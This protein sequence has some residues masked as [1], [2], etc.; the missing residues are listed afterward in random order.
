[1]GEFWE[2]IKSVVNHWQ[3]LGTGGVITFAINWLERYYKPLP[4]RIFAIVF[5]G[6][7][8]FYAC[9]LS[10]SDQHRSL[11]DTMKEKTE[12]S[13]QLSE[14]KQIPPQTRGFLQFDRIEIPRQYSELVSG[15]QFALNLYAVNRGTERVMNARTYSRVFVEDVDEQTDHRVRMLVDKELMPIREQ[16]VAGKIKGAEVGVGRE[17]WNTVATDPLTEREVDGIKKGT[18]RIYSVFWLVWTDFQGRKDFSYNCRWLQA[19]TLPAP[20]SKE[21]IVWH[22]CKEG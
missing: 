12:I 22:I 8:L 11:Q 15:R 14:M 13:R 3:A 7:F 21:D 18:M 19:F 4:K 9:F 1:M 17:L 6:C 2:F 5:G 10:W 16:Y 20:Y